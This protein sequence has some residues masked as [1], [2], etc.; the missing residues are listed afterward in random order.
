MI[1]NYFLAKTIT[2]IGYIIALYNISMRW[3][4]MGSP[5]SKGLKVG[6]WG[7]DWYDHDLKSRY[8]EAK[9]FEKYG[10]TRDIAVILNYILTYIHLITITS[11]FLIFLNRAYLRFKNHSNYKSKGYN[12]TTVLGIIVLFYIIVLHKF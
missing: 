10:F 4:L 3:F 12:V 11:L 2:Y 6:Y 7:L 8:I 9:E 5:L 1:I